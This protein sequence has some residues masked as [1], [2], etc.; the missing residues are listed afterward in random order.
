MA[1]KKYYVFF[2]I[3]AA[4]IW[5]INSLF[6]RSLHTIPPAFIVFLEHA[7]IVLII[8]PIIPRFLPEYKK[9]S[10]K[11]WGILITLGVTSGALATTMYTAALT[12]IQSI[13]YSV[14]ALLQQTQP[15]FTIILASLI[16]KEK[17]TRRFSFF[18]IIALAASY[19]LAFPNFTPSILGN[20]AE[21]IAAALAIGAAFFWGTGT[22][23]S[24]LILK[25]ISY[26]ATAIIRFIIVIPATFIFS[27]FSNQIYPLSNITSNQWLT[28][29][30]LA[31]FSGIVSFII[32][33]KGLQHTEA[34]ISTIAEFTWPLSAAFIGFF[35]LGERLSSFQILAGA[36]L[37]I[38]ILI[39][40]LTSSKK[41]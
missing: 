38:D 19:F 17:I 3:A 26:A 6:R 15:I 1:R 28:L 35:F 39:L 41:V 9:L 11:D 5:S 13:S 10:K 29:I 12:Q 31:L 23:L 27:L 2:I 34:K 37:L 40:S 8:S 16:L 36:V 33:Y 7:I 25:K 4:F 18:A 21:I 14:V 32:Y 24:K 20:Q 30:T 22:I